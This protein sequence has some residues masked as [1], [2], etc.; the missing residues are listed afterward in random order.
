[1]LKMDGSGQVSLRNRKFLRKNQVVADVPDIVSHYT[2]CGQ[3]WGRGSA[4]GSASP[5][6]SVEK[7]SSQLKYRL[8]RRCAGYARR[9]AGYYR[10]DDGEEEGK[11]K[12]TGL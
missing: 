7:T 5:R 3:G 9:C 11:Y 8:F 2:K 1:M 12:A 4:G 10:G 6:T